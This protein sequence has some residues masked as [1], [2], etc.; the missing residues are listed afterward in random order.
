MGAGGHS[1]DKQAG[2]RLALTVSSRRRF[3]LPHALAPA[4]HECFAHSVRPA[5]PL[6]SARATQTPSL[7]AVSVVARPRRL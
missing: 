4:S 1:A 5:L 3:S 6:P 2:R 7:Q